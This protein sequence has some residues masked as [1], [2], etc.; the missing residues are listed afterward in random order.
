[1]TTFAQLWQEGSTE[2]RHLLDERAAIR[3]YDGG[4]TRIEAEIQTA[5]D[6]HKSRWDRMR[7][8][9]EV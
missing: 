7:A 1:M 3:E 9:T 4:L 8:A 6:Y 5:L 2:V